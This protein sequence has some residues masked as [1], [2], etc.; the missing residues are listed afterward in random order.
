MECRLNGLSDSLVRLCAKYDVL[1]SLNNDVKKYYVIGNSSG[2][3][4]DIT[5]KYALEKYNLILIY[6]HC[7]PCKYELQYRKVFEELY[8]KKYGKNIEKLVYKIEDEAIEEHNR[9][10]NQNKN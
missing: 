2:R 5:P 8:L 10:Y 1:I 3:P 9:I 6:T 4:T 7:T